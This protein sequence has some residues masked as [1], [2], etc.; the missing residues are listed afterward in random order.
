MQTK[1]CVQKTDERQFVGTR[2][3][4]LFESKIIDGSNSNTHR[5]FGSL[6]RIEVTLQLYQIVDL[7]AWH[8]NAA[9]SPR[10][11]IRSLE[12]GALARLAQ[13]LGK[14]F[15]SP[16]SWYRMVRRCQNNSSW[17]ESLQGK[18]C[19]NRICRNVAVHVLLIRK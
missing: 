2:S 4:N 17:H 14:V 16:T 18:Q 1:D 13:R 19:E 11:Y 6:K 9:D 7:F 15:A 12:S 5:F 10:G 8:W 3:E